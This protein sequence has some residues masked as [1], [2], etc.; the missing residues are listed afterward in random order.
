MSKKHWSL[1]DIDWS[2][3]D[4]SKVS[5]DLIQVIKTAAMVE[6]NGADYGRYLHGVFR[7]DPAF[8]E[9]A[10]EWAVEEEQH[11]IA[12]GR[13]AALA[14]PSF[15]MEESFKRFT[16]MYKIPVDVEAS[17]RGSRTGELLTSR[18]RLS[19]SA[20]YSCWLLP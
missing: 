16:D 18:I 10:T 8:C 4:A 6:R 15:N 2:R 1:D 14:D 9:A 19:A 3:F 13:W 11:G 5:S 17:I 20:K 7:D 12:L